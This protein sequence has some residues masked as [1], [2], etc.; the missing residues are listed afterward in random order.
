MIF[1]KG[2]MKKYKLTNR[3]KEVSGAILHQ[4]ETMNIFKKKIEAE[5]FV[6]K[7]YKGVCFVPITYVLVN[8]DGQCM[9]IPPEYVYK[10]KYEP[11]TTIFRVHY[12][13]TNN[14]AVATARME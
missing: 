4:G 9:Q 2:T 3:T 13:I 12:K 10:Y 14:K 8:Y 11:G 6:L 1:G 7:L 5:E